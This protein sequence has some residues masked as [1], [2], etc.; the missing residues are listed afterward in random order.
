MRKL[1]FILI[2][3]LIILALAGIIFFR[4][5]K[6]ADTLEIYQDGKLYESLDLNKD[7][8]L[9]IMSFDGEGYNIVTVKD[10]M[11][12]VSEAD[13]PDGLCMKQGVIS[14]NGQTIC[15]L[16]HRLELRVKSHVKSD[17]DVLAKGE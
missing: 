8:S 9:R 1:D 10:G 13:C 7:A 5:Q 2:G 14:K 6:E 4:T 16:P 12:Y 3:I 11:A 17:I 15:C